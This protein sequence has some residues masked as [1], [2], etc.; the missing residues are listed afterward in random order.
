MC[1]KQF[2][3]GF[4]FFAI[5]LFGLLFII[6]GCEKSTTNPNANDFELSQSA[7]Q[8]LTSSWQAM[9]SVNSVS[10]VSSIVSGETYLDES[11]I[12]GIYTAPQLRQEVEKLNSGLQEALSAEVTEG[13][14][15]GDS[16]LWFIDWSDPISG[17]SVRKAL[18]Y[19]T[20]T[21]IA[22]YYEAI[23]EFP[24]QLRLDYDSTQI[25]VD[26]N[27]TL[28]DSTDDKFLNLY[29]LTEFKDGFYVDKIEADAEATDWDETNEVT[30]AILNNHVW[31][32]QQSRLSELTQELELNPDESGHINERLDYRDG[33]YLEKTVNFYDDY[34]GDFSERWRNGTEVSGT[35]DRIEDDNHASLTRLVDFPAGFFLDKIEQL[36]DVTVDPQDSSSN[37]LFN[38]K[39]YFA[40]GAL[41]TSQLEID[42]YF[43]D[44]LK[45]TH[46]VGAKSDGSQA[47]LLVTHYQEYQEI[48]GHYI[49]PAGYFSLINAI[50]YSDGSGELWLKVYENQQA[51]LNGDPPLVTI[52][53]H[54][55]PDGSGDGTITEGDN[56][57][58]VKVDQNGEMQVTNN[59]GKTKIVNGF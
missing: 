7:S 10:E 49:G 16:L 24:A 31:Y 18:Y 53:I 43:E 22:R 2:F 45:K 20:G 26:L 11:D 25:R 29:K 23:Y 34:T 9:H 42:E 57:Y 27:Y 5:L 52:Y 28:E 13:V 38:E 19:N 30:G 59:E 54:F 8:G 3:E 40:S 4:K 51:Y 50:L 32:G 39:I 12:G 35:F 44:G 41:D 36:A 47:D 58:T 37:M 1:S 55:N 6:T 17:I 33:T 14:Q 48:D 15:T 56:Q 21:G 46:L